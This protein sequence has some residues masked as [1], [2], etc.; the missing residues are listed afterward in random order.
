MG[1]RTAATGA[2]LRLDAPAKLN[3]SL[4]VMGRRPDGYHQ[5]AGVMVLLQHADTVAV[6]PGTGELAVIA[7][8]GD[9]LAVPPTE[10]LAW[11]GLRSGLGRE[12]SSFALELVKRIPVAAGMG[13]GSSDAA[14]AWR[15]GRRLRGAAERPDTQTLAALAQLGADVPFFAAAVAAAYVTG[16]GERV[17][18]L[19]ARR[20]E[21]VVA[22]PPHRLATAA[23]FEELRRSDWSAA[24][25][26]H[27]TEPGRND[28]LAPALRLCPEL[29]DVMGAIRRA[30]GEPWLTGSGPACYTLTDDPD[31]AAATADA[32][33]RAGLRA[34]LTHTRER[35]TEIEERPA[36]A[37]PMEER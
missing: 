31:R 8:E 28:L 16:I 24:E 30:G 19:G 3:V 29:E 4:A 20:H 25:P 21:V 32:L 14:A 34:I 23:V 15:L 26:A 33:R 17:Q 12:P 37:A 7:S 27:R 2:R 5:L 18:P 36:V 11:R 1:P 13:G 6:A 35:T 10:N 9:S 22:I